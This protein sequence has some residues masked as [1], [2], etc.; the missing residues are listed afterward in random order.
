MHLI[1]AFDASQRLPVEVRRIR[2]RAGSVR[3]HLRWAG[4]SRKKP[5]L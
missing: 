2:S 1:F 3:A 4:L 5:P